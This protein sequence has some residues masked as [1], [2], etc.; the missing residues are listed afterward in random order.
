MTEASDFA[1]AGIRLDRPVDDELDHILGPTQAPITLVEY[2]SYACPHC[3]AA[4]ARI[5]EVRNQLGE[6]L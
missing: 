1:A 4:N 6:R 2:G 3:R 5:T